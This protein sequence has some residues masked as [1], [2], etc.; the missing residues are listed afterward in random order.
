MIRY[1]KVPSLCRFLGAALVAICFWNSGKLEALEPGAAITASSPAA[2]APVMPAGYYGMHV[3]HLPYGTAWPTTTFGAW[4]LWDSYVDWK[5]LEPAANVYSWATLDTYIA[6]AQQKHIDVLLE[7]GQTP[8]WASAR[9]NETAGSGNGAAAEPS[10]DQYWIN[11]VTAVATRYKGKIAYY[12]IW[13]EANSKSYFSGTPAKL[14]QLTA[15]ANKAI[16]AVDPAAKIV[17][18]SI[19]RADSDVLPWLK[20]LLDAGIGS[21]V[22]VIG[23]HFYSLGKTPE[24][25]LTYTQAV[26]ALLKIY[27]LTSKPVFCTEIGW[28]SPTTFA[29]ED[30][31]SG[32]YIRTAL[33][34]W[35]GGVSRLFWY[36]WDNS[37]WVTLTMT[38]SDFK[39]PTKP[40]AAMT[41]LEGWTVGKEVAPCV[42]SG[43]TWSCDIT[44]TSGDHSR[45]YWNTTGSA[46]VT[47]TLPWRPSAV[48]DMYGNA[49]KYTGGKLAITDLPV[50]VRE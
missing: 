47:P 29:N 35:T 17:S 37:N 28:A 14:V 2:T 12:E 43:T 34:G 41:T 9:P 46:T 5:Q 50:L 8:Q 38:L 24:A 21:S 16:K 30:E 22:D 19:S 11:Y 7:L 26:Q 42:V 18:P 31:Q 27:G 45:I 6:L 4:R 49:T 32:W 33:M 23:V 40:A 44:D 39:T 36:A 3:L 25:V 1:N 15:E 10:N 48:V 13:N 20:S